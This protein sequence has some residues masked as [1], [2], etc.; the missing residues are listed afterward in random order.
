MT[1]NIL[2]VDDS[3]EID[4]QVKPYANTFNGSWTLHS[5]GERD[6]FYKALEVNADC[7]LIDASS[8]EGNVWD[9]IR[10]LREQRQTQSIPVIILFDGKEPETILPYTELEHTDF[11]FKPFNMK[12]LVIRLEALRNRRAYLE[13][14]CR[15]NER[16]NDLTRVADN[17]ASALVVFYPDG[18]IEWSNKGFEMIYG[19][20]LTDYLNHF[21]HEIFSPTSQRLRMIAD[22][23]DQGEKVFTL[24]HEIQTTGGKKK[25]VQTTVTP[26]LDDAGKLNKMVAVESDITQLREE[27][28]KSD[29]LLL[30]ILPFEI[31]EQLKKKGT[32]KSKKYKT[33]TVMFA[34]FANFTGMTKV[35]TVDELIDEL[36]L[37]VRNF[38]EIIGRH[39]IEKI[40]TIGDAYMCAGGLPLKNK[41]NPLDVT[42]ASLEIQKFVSEMAKRNQNQNKRIWQLRMGIHTGE[43]MAGVI[44]SKRFAYDIWGSTVN[45]ASKMEEFSQVG[46]INISS[47]T[48]QYI[49][50]YFDT[51]Y[52][53]KVRIKNTPDVLD[54]YF[55]NRLKP[56]YSEDEEG[57]YPNKAFLKILSQ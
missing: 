45:I 33:V 15:E 4:R 7:I 32:A 54:T 8:H 21:E 47:D 43:V 29:Q 36:N 6:I 52:R 38:D 9:A 26:L 46:R 10:S 25:W 42:L 18:K 27:K 11:L 40:K 37:Y 16:L 22:Q 3:G 48:Y 2:V 17:T 44:G 31:A 20:P 57:I 53:G 50:D 56:E 35:M 28:T 5:A 51:S 1:Q 14:L 34:D 12:E 41:S 13:S 24:E 30:N 55:V 39:Y 49:R 19:S 23:F